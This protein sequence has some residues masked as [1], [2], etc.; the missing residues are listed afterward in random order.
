MVITGGWSIFV[1]LT[2]LETTQKNEV[3]LQFWSIEAFLFFL[4]LPEE[5]PK[6]F[7]VGLQ[8]RWPHSCSSGASCDALETEIRKRC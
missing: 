3:Q 2:L 8:P 7:P 1:L 5:W 6:F 4:V